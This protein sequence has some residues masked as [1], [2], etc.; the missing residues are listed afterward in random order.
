MKTRTLL[1][2]AAA[3]LALSS[4]PAFA[5][6]M[7]QGGMQMNH[8]EMNAPAAPAG[9]IAE[10][11]VKNGVRVVE[12]E[13][14]GEGFVPARVKV[15]K[16]EKVRLLITR[17]TDRTCATE[18]VIKDYGINVPLPLNKTVKV[19]LTPKAPGEIHYACAMNMIG[20]V[21]FVP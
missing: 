2:P 15:K 3:A 5:Q 4:A 21:L 16:G 13:V 9:A 10:G 20:G 8:G 14:T 11:V 7:G 6:H 1:L 12:M 17:K 19:E 18:I